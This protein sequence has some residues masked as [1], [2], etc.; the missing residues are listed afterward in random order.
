MVSAI[1]MR[2][3]LKRGRIHINLML[4]N[5]LKQYAILNVDKGGSI[6]WEWGI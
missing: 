6:R 5:K 4:V 1:V 2:I 3:G